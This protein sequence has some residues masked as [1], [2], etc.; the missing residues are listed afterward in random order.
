MRNNVQN[1]DKG[2]TLVLAWPLTLNSNI[3]SASKLD[4][5]VGSTLFSHIS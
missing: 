3:E 4:W 1:K 5:A 2:F